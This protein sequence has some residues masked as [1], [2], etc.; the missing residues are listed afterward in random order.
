MFVTVHQ[1]PALVFTPS[2]VSIV[3]PWQD[4]SFSNGRKLEQHPTQKWTFS[5]AFPPS[6]QRRTPKAFTLPFPE[7]EKELPQKWQWCNVRAFQTRHRVFLATYVRILVQI[8]SPYR[9]LKSK[10]GRKNRS[11]NGYIP[12]K[13]TGIFEMP[14]YDTIATEM[15]TCSIELTS[16][17]LSSQ[18]LMGCC[19]QGDRAHCCE[20]L[21]PAHLPGHGV[22]PSIVA[23]PL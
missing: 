3:S 14:V 6:D 20:L 5:W 11:E 18:E 22:N 23:L 8:S 17:I 9:Q 12:N 15:N 16:V 21:N 1:F 2:S 7:G 19:R 4:A 10:M 13:L